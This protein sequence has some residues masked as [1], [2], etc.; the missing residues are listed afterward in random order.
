MQRAFAI[1]SLISIYVFLILI[2]SFFSDD[3]WAVDVDLM[4]L[5]VPVYIN[6]QVFSEIILLMAEKPELNQL[7]LAD[8]M[9]IIT[10]YLSKNTKSALTK[11]A[12]NQSNI[13]FKAL[14][15]Q[16]VIARFDE[17]SI[18][19]YIDITAKN[20]PIKTTNLKHKLWQQTAINQ[21]ILPKSVSAGVVLMLHNHVSKAFE[22]PSILI[23]TVM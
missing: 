4:E 15:E 23:L 1:R 7:V 18:A 22:I 19:I 9:K 10:P 13:T 16:G 20:R 21:A 2:I 12:E 3:S 17:E 6:N 11:I 8:L 5:F 14:A